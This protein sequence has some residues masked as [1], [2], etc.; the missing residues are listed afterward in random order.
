MIVELEETEFMVGENSVE[1]CAVVTGAQEREVTVS[2]TTSDGTATASSG[3][4]HSLSANVPIF[5]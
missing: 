2:L 4:M 1:V 3:G 5:M